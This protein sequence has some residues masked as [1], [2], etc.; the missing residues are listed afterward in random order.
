MPGWFGVRMLTLV[1]WVRPT[2]A[3]PTLFGRHRRR[4]WR[5]RGG[6]ENIAGRA[7]RRREGEQGG[8][9]KHGTLLLGNG[10]IAFAHWSARFPEGSAPGPHPLHFKLQ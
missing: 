2:L 4:A 10:E 1:M 9:A 3:R 7:W 5:Q 6:Q 8:L